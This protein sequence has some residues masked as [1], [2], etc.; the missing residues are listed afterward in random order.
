MRCP[1]AG[2]KMWSGPFVPT[3][4][5]RYSCCDVD[6]DADCLIIHGPDRLRSHRKG[7][8]DDLFPSRTRREPNKP[9][10]VCQNRR[11]R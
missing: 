3:L 6:S 10:G 1:A 2:M 4:H 9:E 7:P 5:G 8:W 11:S